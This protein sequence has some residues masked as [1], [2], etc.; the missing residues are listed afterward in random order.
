MT[1]EIDYGEK[2]QAQ[3]A[4]GSHVSFFNFLSYICLAKFL[5]LNISCTM[6]LSMEVI[7][8]Q[9]FCILEIFFQRLIE[10]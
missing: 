4:S 8:M 6:S 10:G 2:V 3:L 1:V 7:C 5:L 9:K